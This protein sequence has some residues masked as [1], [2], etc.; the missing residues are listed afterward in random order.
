MKL[1]TLTEPDRQTPVMINKDLIF[2]YFY[3]KHFNCTL[4]QASGGGM[5]KVSEKPE[6]IKTKLLEKG[7]ED[8]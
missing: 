7:Q 8:E 3:S 5:V 6:E 4:V 1:V 2:S